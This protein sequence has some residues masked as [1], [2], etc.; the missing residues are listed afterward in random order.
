[1]ERLTALARDPARL[2]VSGAPEG[3]D[4]YAAAEAALRGNGLVL[5]ICADGQRASAAVDAA[6]FF[7]PDLKVLHFPAWDCLPY[8]RVSPRSDIESERL[9]TLAQ[10]AS[11]GERAG[12][13]LVITTVNAAI[14]RVPPRKDVAQASFLAK[15]GG[16][17][18]L[19]ALT[20]FLARNSYVRTATVR[21]P[22]EYA[23]RGANL[24]LTGGRL[25]Q[26]AM[27]LLVVAAEER[28]AQ[29]EDVT[30]LSKRIAEYE[31]WSGH[32]AGR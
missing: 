14:Q 30:V 32:T 22:G 4:A 18:D 17:V 20:L 3:Y 15:S 24:P 23:L 28:A 21:E 1:L 16:Y 13:A 7:A 11:R 12:P 9:A 8:D 10:L 31:S 2:S 6:R 19:D 5:F 25:L 26:A 27:G 29:G